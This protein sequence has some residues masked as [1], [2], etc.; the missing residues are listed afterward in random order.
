MADVKYLS[1]QAIRQMVL[2]RM[3]WSTDDQNLS[4]GV[5]NQ[6]NEFIRQAN[7]KVLDLCEWEPNLH[8]ATFVTGIAQ[9]AYNYP[10]LDVDGITFV[11]GPTSVIQVSRFDPNGQQYIDLTRSRIGLEAAID[12]SLQG[13]DLTN[14]LD[15]PLRYELRKQLLLHP[16]PDQAYTIRVLSTDNPDIASGANPDANISVVDAEA[17][18]IYATALCKREDGDLQSAMSMALAPG[19]KMWDTEF[20]AH[21]LA[22]KR[23]MSSAAV[24]KP[25]RN[26]WLRRRYRNRLTYVERYGRDRWMPYG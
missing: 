14:K 13:S 6:V 5:V 26:E 24:M 18:A 16:V 1:R 25:G 19:A 9:R 11:S 20:G 17:I 12:E 3:G 10:T 4:A 8:E 7:T 21:V 23:A 2:A 15:K 22:I